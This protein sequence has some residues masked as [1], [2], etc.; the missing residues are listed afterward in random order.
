MDTP[1]LTVVTDLE[2]S[3]LSDI[4]EIPAGKISN[5]KRLR[6]SDVYVF[7]I[8]D[9]NLL[10][11]SEFKTKIKLEPKHTEK[12]PKMSKSPQSYQVPKWTPGYDGLRSFID[13]M[14]ACKSLQIFESDSDLIYSSLCKSNK[15]ELYSQ[16]PEEEKQSVEKFAKYLNRNFG[17]SLNERKRRFNHLTQM[18]DED[19][20]Q[21]FL[22]TTREYFAAK[23][24]AVPQESDFTA[25]NKSDISLAFIA[26]LRKAELKRLMKLSLDE[27]D[28]NSNFF[29]LG[30]MAQRKA[31]SL[32]E[33][34]G[35]IY[36]V[37]ANHTGVFQTNTELQKEKD[38][39]FEENMNQLV[40]QV[41][42]LNTHSKRDKACYNCGRPG[43]FKAECRASVKSKR[44]FN[45]GQ[46]RKNQSGRYGQRGRQFNQY[47]SRSRSN[48][49]FKHQNRQRTH[50]RNG[51]SYSREHSRDRFNRDR[52]SSRGRYEN[53]K[54]RFVSF[55]D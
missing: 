19:E 5:Q 27:E 37:G 50:S 30:K 32:R 7:A 35:S 11:D 20:N 28:E 14:D 49:R 44:A 22:R 8:Q 54:N 18:E 26:G 4:L 45:K 31:L 23:G 46:N 6:I 2:R 36:T 16:L 53:R 24:T 21:W 17:P 29:S 39:K 34:E 33:L 10:K 47:R 1:T 55:R 15:P 43:H 52:S 42:R 9:E 38:G 40:Q 13:Q 12:K 3:E 51:R 41:R 25:E 48:G